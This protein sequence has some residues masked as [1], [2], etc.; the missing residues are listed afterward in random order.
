[1]KK[2]KRNFKKFAENLKYDAIKFDFEGE[3]NW[4][5]S[6]NNLLIDLDFG[7]TEAASIKLN[8]SFTD[9]STDVLDLSGPPL[10]V[11]LMSTPKFKNLNLTI[12]DH[13][14]KNRLIDFGADQQDMTSQQYKDYLTQSINIFVTTFATNNKLAESMK[15]AVTNFINKSNKITLSVKPFKPLSITDLITLKEADFDK[16]ITKLN[17]F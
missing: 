7:I 1:M 6:R 16:I 15:Q 5:T 3:W 2:V 4:N 13:S 9:L 11:Y 10:G 8:T 17:C 12:K 14:L